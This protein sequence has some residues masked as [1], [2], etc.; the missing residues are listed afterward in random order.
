MA[1]DIIAEDIMA[2]CFYAIGNGAGS[3]RIRLAAV[4]EVR[5]FF[6]PKFEKA[7]ADNGPKKW[8]DEGP[9]VLEY[10]RTIGRLASQLATTNARHVISVEDMRLALTEVVSTNQ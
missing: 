5:D 6:V 9:F 2:Q 3:M 4:Q 7:L 1:R 10:F 8:D